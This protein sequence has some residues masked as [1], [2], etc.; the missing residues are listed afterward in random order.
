[1]PL[2]IFQLNPN[3]SIKTISHGTSVPQMWHKNRRNICYLLDI[4]VL[5]LSTTWLP[6]RKYL[7][8]YLEF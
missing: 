7:E 6:D 4:A 3:I 8:D 1:L 2:A 5:D